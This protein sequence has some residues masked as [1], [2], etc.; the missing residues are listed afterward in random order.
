MQW[1]VLKWV[2]FKLGLFLKAE[3][4]M[5]LPWYCLTLVPSICP[6]FPSPSFHK[7]YLY[8][9]T[10]Q[11]CVHAYACHGMHVEVRGEL[12]GIDPLASPVCLDS[13]SSSSFSPEIPPILPA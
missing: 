3:I 4:E 5:A 9:H 7:C 6:P 11:E 2:G 1:N 12:C 10:G 8:L 13:S